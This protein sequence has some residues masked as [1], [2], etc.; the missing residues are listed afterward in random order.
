MTKIDIHVAWGLRP[1][2]VAATLVRLHLGLLFQPKLLLSARANGPL[3]RAY[4]AIRFVHN[5][6][7]N[8][9]GQNLPHKCRRALRNRCEISISLYFE[10]ANLHLH[11]CLVGGIMR[12]VQ[13]K[14]LLWPPYSPTG[15]R[16]S[17]QRPIPTRAGT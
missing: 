1:W 6:P 14:K 3:A 8:C 11:I 12:A 10:L 7:E 16:H 9:S 15:V 5:N 4:K 17:G 13:V 2:Y